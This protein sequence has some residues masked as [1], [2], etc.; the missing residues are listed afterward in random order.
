[1]QC[2]LLMPQATLTAVHDEHWEAQGILVVRGGGLV[3]YA[4][5]TAPPL[6]VAKTAQALTGPLLVQAAAAQPQAVGA[7]AVQAA[8]REAAGTE[9]EARA[10]PGA[11]AQ[12]A[13]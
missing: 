4:T 9:G 3:S 12:R 11:D 1:M 7:R 5:A 13:A 10:G 2:V 8:Q 6:H